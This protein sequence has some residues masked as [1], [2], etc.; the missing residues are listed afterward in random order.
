MSWRGNLENETNQ[1]LYKCSI[2]SSYVSTRLLTETQPVLCHEPLLPYD[3]EQDP[4]LSVVHVNFML[5]FC[6]GR[7]NQ[8]KTLSSVSL[9]AVHNET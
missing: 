9:A 8:L 1:Q 6:G 3:S 5:T 2:Y 7:Q 4:S